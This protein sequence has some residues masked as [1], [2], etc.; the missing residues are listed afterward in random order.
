MEKILSQ[1]EVNALL[2]GVENGAV[3]TAAEAQ[4]AGGARTYDLTSQD[5]IIR[6]RMPSLEIINERFCRIQQVSLSSML[7]KIVDIHPA[8]IETVKFGEFMKNIPLPSC[9]N[10]FKMEPLRGHGI[11]VIDARVVYLLVDH[12]FGGAGQTH[13]KIEGRDF[14]PI[15]HR[16]IRKVVLQV[17]QDLQKAWN[18]VHAVTMQ[19]QRTEV[20][21]QFAAIVTPTEVVILVTFEIEIDGITGKMTFTQNDPVKC[22]VIVKISDKGEFEFYKSVC[23]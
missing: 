13:V 21:P 15:E 6:G 3:E 22:A 7:R 23:P 4:D 20:N 11:V 10:I 9:I 19:Y 18:P 12:F 16:V 14:T 1:D 17:L 5:R 2:R 8:M